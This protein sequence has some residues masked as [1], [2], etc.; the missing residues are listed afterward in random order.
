M[1]ELINKIKQ[2]I[3]KTVHGK[4]SQQKRM[5]QLFLTKFQCTVYKKSEFV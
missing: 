1:A 4:T 2:T 3:T 5:S